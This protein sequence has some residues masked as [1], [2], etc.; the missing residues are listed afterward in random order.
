[1]TKI[2]RQLLHGI[3]SN[4]FLV[5]LMKLKLKKQAAKI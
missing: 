5:I 2:D 1:M 4:K 3:Q